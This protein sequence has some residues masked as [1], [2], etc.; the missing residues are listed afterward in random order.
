MNQWVSHSAALQQTT[1]T[2]SLIPARGLSHGNLGHLSSDMSYQSYRS[3][4]SEPIT[5]IRIEPPSQTSERPKRSKTSGDSG[6]PNPPG[7]LCTLHFAFC[8]LHSDRKRAAHPQ[9]RWPHN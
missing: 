8:T 5:E 6:T 7:P 4:K 2:N 1:E 3:D 9:S